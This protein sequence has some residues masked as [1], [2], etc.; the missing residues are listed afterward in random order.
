MNPVLPRPPPMSIGAFGRH[1]SELFRSKR[2]INGA[3]RFRYSLSLRRGLAC[4]WWARV[5]RDR[6]FP[7]VPP[8]ALNKGVFD[9]AMFHASGNRNKASWFRWSLANHQSGNEMLA[10]NGGEGAARPRFR[11]R[12]ERSRAYSSLPHLDDFPG[13]Q[14]RAHGHGGAGTGGPLRLSYT[15]AY[16]CINR[17]G[18]NS[19]R[20]PDFLTYPLPASG[21][22]LRREYALIYRAGLLNKTGPFEVTLR[23]KLNNFADSL[24][25]ALTARNPDCG[26]HALPCRS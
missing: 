4:C 13:V 18:A 6:P 15:L 17:L 21:A 14:R 26:G 9:A 23:D 3:L 19:E 10:L 12:G 11:P 7:D 20:Q 2:P 16:R 24:S 5:E 1:K 22:L 8:D 25:K